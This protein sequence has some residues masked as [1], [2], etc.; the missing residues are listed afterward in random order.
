MMTIRKKLLIGLVSGVVVTFLAVGIGTYLKVRHE[1]NELFDYQLK[2]IV[3]SFPPHMGMQQSETADRHP[4]KK[5]VVQVWDQQQLQV[6]ISNPERQLPRYS[7]TGFFEVSFKDKKWRIY[8]EENFQQRVQVA[9]LIV[10]REKIEFS[11]ALRSLIPFLIMLPVLM[12]LIWLMVGHSLKPLNRLADTLQQRSPDALL[13]IEKTGYTPEILPIIEAMNALFGRVEQAILQQ[14]MFVADAAHELRTPLAALKLQLQLAESAD[15]DAERLRAIRKLHE[16]LNRATH[17]VQQ[18]LTL[19]RHS[20]EAEQHDSKSVSL[21]W[22]AQQAVSDFSLQA[23]HQQIDLG[24]DLQSDAGDP[25][26]GPAST[27]GDAEALRIMLNNLIDNAIRYAG[28][29]SRID[30]IVQ[31][32]QQHT[33]LIVADS[34]PGIP[35]DERSRIFDRFYRVIG[36]QHSGSGLGLAIVSHIAQLHG[37]TLEVADNPDQRGIRFIVSFGVAA[38]HP[39][40][41]PV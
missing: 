7:E 15:S 21:A 26:A 35:A 4:G 39:A 27:V 5:I 31:Q 20:G 2:Q 6:F 17:L 38:G 12:L 40:T 36:N 34:G 8:S 10:D 9:Q 11:L 32:D 25:A 30:V 24:V 1:L 29:G 22:L 13:P 19:A 41:H 23:E 33:R 16:R 37:A 3:R 14:K 28:A 18:L